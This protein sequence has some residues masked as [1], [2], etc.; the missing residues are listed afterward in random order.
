MY[1]RVTLRPLHPDVSHEEVFVFSH[2]WVPLYFPDLLSYPDAVVP[3]PEV[4]PPL[5]FSVG[6]VPD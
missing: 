1:I 2:P 3:E 6:H 5:H 4:V